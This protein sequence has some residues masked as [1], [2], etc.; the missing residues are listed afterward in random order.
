MIVL[1]LSSIPDMSSLTTSMDNPS[2]LI[3][4][5]SMHSFSRE[6]HFFT[7]YSFKPLRSLDSSHSIFFKVEIEISCQFSFACI[8]LVTLSQ[9]FLTHL[10]L[11]DSVNLRSDCTEAC[12]LIML[13]TL[14]QKEIYPLFF[15]NQ[16]PLSLLPFQI[17]KLMLLSI[18]LKVLFR[19]LRR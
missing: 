1:T 10:P 8:S 2:V 14:P 13:S 11:L 18:M 16:H 5:L 9:L 19:I 4:I 15:A 17:A 6:R 7:D 12:I 3:S